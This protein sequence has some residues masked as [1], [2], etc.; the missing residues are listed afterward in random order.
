MPKNW[1]KFE[2]DLARKTNSNRTP[3]SGNGKLEGDLQNKIWCIECK[4]TSQDYITFRIDWLLKIIK[5]AGRQKR[6]PAFAIEFNNKERI[7][8]VR[9]RDIVTDK[10]RSKEWKDKSTIRLKPGDLEIGDLI[11]TNFGNWLVVDI[12]VLKS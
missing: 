12:S 6:L 1:E 10:Y 11:I 7:F 3:G 8:L 9:E 2:S 4:E 5:E